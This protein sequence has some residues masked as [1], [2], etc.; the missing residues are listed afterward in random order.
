[1]ENRNCPYRNICEHSN[2]CYET[3]R[4][5]ENWCPYAKDFARQS[6]ELELKYWNSLLRINSSLQSK[7]ITGKVQVENGKGRKRTK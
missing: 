6:D 3:T 4:D 1:M 2:A 7:S 5:E